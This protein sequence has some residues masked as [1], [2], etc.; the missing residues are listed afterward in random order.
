MRKRNVTKTIVT[1]DVTVMVLNKATKEVRSEEMTLA[2]VYKNDSEMI[3]A[4]N[5]SGELGQ[6]DICVTVENF[7]LKTDT[8]TMTEADFICTAQKV[9]SGV[10]AATE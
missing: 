4:V 1:T 6:D 3:A 5:E 9:G 10:K 8:Y 7:E 2:G